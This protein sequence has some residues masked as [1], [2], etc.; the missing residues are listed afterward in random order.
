M[1]ARYNKPIYSGGKSTCTR[2]GRPKIRVTPPKDGERNRYPR[3]VRAG[4]A[5]GGDCVYAT[6]AVAHGW[7]SQ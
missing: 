7:S 1:S 3:T 6:E 4:C 5:Q 2:C